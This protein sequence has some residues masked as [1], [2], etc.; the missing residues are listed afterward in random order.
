[1]GS[2]S[3]IVGVDWCTGRGVGWLVCWLV[4]VCV[5]NIFSDKGSPSGSRIAASGACPS[6]CLVLHVQGSEYGVQQPTRFGHCKAGV[7]ETRRCVCIRCDV[8]CVGPCLRIFREQLSNTCLLRCT[9]G[10]MGRRHYCHVE[11][12]HMDEHMPA[13]PPWLGN[14]RL[15]RLGDRFAMLLT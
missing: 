11:P 9:V 13:Y 14:H 15:V 12:Y 7:S 3:G 4:C 5:R 6:R 1:M 2:A 8:L 10:R